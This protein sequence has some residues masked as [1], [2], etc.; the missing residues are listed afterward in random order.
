VAGDAG[1]WHRSGD[2]GHV[3][4]HGRLW[5]EGRTV[6]V[7]RSAAGPVT[8]VPVELAA[9][10][11]GAVRRAAAVGIGPAGVQQV[12]VVV[13]TQRAGRRNG[14]VDL[15]PIGLTDHVRHAVRSA[16]GVEVAAVLQ[17]GDL[18]VDIRHNAKIDRTALAARAERFLAGSAG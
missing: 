6:H 5:I 11:C 9:E 15:A 1:R 14:R 4:D 17:I 12:V 3:D 18:P 13:E 8:P 10:T 16:T 2:V 7:V